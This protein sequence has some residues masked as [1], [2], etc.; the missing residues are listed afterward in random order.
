MTG[1]VVSMDEDIRALCK[2][3]GNNAATIQVML[4]AARRLRR[5]PHMPVLKAWAGFSTEAHARQAIKAG[6]VKFED[7]FIPPP[8]VH[9]WLLLTSKGKAW[10]ER[11]E[12][13]I[14]NVLDQMICSEGHY[15]SKT[16]NAVLVGGRKA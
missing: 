3:T 1:K 12:N 16:A 5:L 8:H 10:L 6:L 15:R 9:N 2:K 14:N 4:E 11:Y 7:G 13:D